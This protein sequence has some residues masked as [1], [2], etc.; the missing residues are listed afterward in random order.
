MTSDYLRLKYAFFYPAI[1]LLVLWLV[2][3]AEFF[4]DTDW[5]YLGLKPRDLVH[6]Y[7]IFSSIFLHGDFSHLFANSF[8]LL[9]LGATLFY[10][11]KKIAFKVVF[12]GVLFTGFL[13]WLVARPSTHIGASG[14]V[15]VLA[16]FIFTSGVISKQRQLMAISMMVIF[17]Y[18]GMIWGVLPLKSGI[19]WESHLF[20]G[21]V[22]VVFAFV[23]KSNYFVVEE[24]E[25]EIVKMK[26]STGN[27][28]TEFSQ[29]SHT[30]GFEEFSFTYNFFSEKNLNNNKET[31]N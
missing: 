23:F 11:H 16:A 15:Y 22:G 26:R 13:V 27:F 21:V 4:L 6:L 31:G 2:K 7:G 30:A 1:F 24:P 14:L 28:D 5:S 10:F 25:P 12:W 18:G 19:S 9:V 8:P 29:I 3:I 20:G 17:L